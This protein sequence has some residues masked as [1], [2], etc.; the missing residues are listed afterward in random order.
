MNTGME[1][2]RREKPIKSRSGIPSFRSAAKT[3]QKIP[4][5]QANSTA[6]TVSFSVFPKAAVD[7]LPGN[8][9]AL[10]V[11]IPEAIDQTVKGWL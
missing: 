3:P 5:H 9:H 11:A 7:L 4:R 6:A 1:T 2:P 8:E 10:P